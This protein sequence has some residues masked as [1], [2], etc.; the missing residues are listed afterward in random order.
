M[1]VLS[2]RP[3]PKYLTS[4]TQEYMKH[5]V[6]YEERGFFEVD[7]YFSPPP[8]ANKILKVRSFW[9]PRVSYSVSLMDQRCD[10]PDF[11]FRADRDRNH[12]SRLCKHLVVKLNEFDAFESSNE[13]IKLLA[14][15]GTRGPIAAF[16]IRTEQ[17]TPGLMAVNDKEDWVD[18]YAKTTKKGET[19]KNASGAF[20][21]YGWAIYQKRWSHGN[22]PRGGPH[23]RKILSQIDA[24]NFYEQTTSPS[25][26]YR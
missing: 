25:R 20:H 24:L 3:R 10:C 7:L 17:T 9:N 8:I 11:Q 19:A 23:Y 12:I 13:W 2:R 4:A 6:G 1:S 22:Y 16:E 5:R 14:G 26:K 15:M 18:F 21:R